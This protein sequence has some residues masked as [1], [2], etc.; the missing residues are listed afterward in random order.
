MLNKLLFTSIFTIITKNVYIKEWNWKIKYI[1]INKLG[2]VFEW[3]QSHASWCPRVD[4][5]QMLSEEY[6]VGCSYGW[7]DVCEGLELFMR[8]SWASNCHWGNCGA[9]QR[10]R[11]HS[12]NRNTN[13]SRALSQVMHCPPNP[14]V[15][16]RVGWRASVECRGFTEKARCEGATSFDTKSEILTDQ[17]GDFPK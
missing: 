2:S 17:G 14:K 11:A 6:A 12:V 4:K 9:L 1:N 10:L 3:H 8:W 7:G 16:F 13:L 5:S 15:F